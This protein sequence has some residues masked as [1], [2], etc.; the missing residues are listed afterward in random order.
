MFQQLLIETTRR[1]IL[2]TVKR[3]HTQTMSFTLPHARAYLFA[4]PS[5]NLGL[6]FTNSEF[7][8]TL[9]RQ[10]R[11]QI[12]D[13]TRT[14]I[15]CNTSL[16]DTFGDL[17]LSYLTSSD[18]IPRENDTRDLVFHA[19]RSAGLSPILPAKGLSESSRR[20]PGDI[21]I[22]NWAHGSRA[23]VDVTPTCRLQPI[24]IN[25]AAEEVGYAC[26]LAE[27]RK[28]AASAEL[29]QQSGFE[30]TT[31]AIKNKRWVRLQCDFGQQRL[32]RT[33]TCVKTWP[34]TG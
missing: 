31:L 26:K 12:C 27:E 10:F 14:C 5:R 16:M 30:F 9:C 28:F 18:R 4:K 22:P 34:C 29:C 23:A 33:T 20:V 3:P 17:A 15:G 7:R 1:V 11:V 6:K 32:A 8:I 24:V 21:F 13:Q 19:C 2:R 25:R